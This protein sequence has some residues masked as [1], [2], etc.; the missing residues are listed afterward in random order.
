[1]MKRTVGSEYLINI[2][3]ARKIIILCDMDG[4]LINTDYANYLS[5]RCAIEVVVCRNHD[6]QF[7]PEKRLN[8][9]GLKE[10]FP[11]LTD[12]QYKIFISLD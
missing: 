7:N 11:Q 12:D 3:I 1:M 2:E 10:K 8:R 5:Y 4:T 9:E 6:L